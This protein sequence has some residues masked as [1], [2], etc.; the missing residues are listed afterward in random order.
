MIH[1]RRDIYDYYILVLLSYYNLIIAIKE[2]LFSI[3]SVKSVYITLLSAS[4]LPTKLVVLL[5]YFVL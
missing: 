3:D 1:D 4:N 2:L 5:D